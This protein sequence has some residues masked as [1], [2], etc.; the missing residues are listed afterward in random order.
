MDFEWR[1]GTE[2][3]MGGRGACP[4]I[5]LTSDSAPDEAGLSKLEIE[6]VVDASYKCLS[7]LN[8]QSKVVVLSPTMLMLA[9][10]T[11]IVTALAAACFWSSGRA[12]ATAAS[13]D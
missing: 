8:G 10:R 2:G 4:K 6:L 7:D 1:R 11:G 12:R 9:P 13:Q 5:A 3:G